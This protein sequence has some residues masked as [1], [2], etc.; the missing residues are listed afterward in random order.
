MSIEN[1]NLIENRLN[2]IKLT[3][4]LFL[5]YDYN[6]ETIIILMFVDCYFH[7]HCVPQCN[8]NFAFY[9]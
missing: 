1:L 4:I 6:I 9:K 8:P 2:K 3:H 5:F 7:L